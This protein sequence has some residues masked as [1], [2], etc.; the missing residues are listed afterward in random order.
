MRW[1]LL[2]ILLPGNNVMPVPDETD[3]IRSVKASRITALGFL[4]IFFYKLC[5]KKRELQQKRRAAPAEKKT[6][7]VEEIDELI[8]TIE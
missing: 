4:S 3:A 7:A 1:I 8:N 6:A 2:L 5:G